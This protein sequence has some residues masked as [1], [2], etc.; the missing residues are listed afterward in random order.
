MSKGRSV[1]CTKIWYS[2][3]HQ[4]LQR[5]KDM[6]EAST[7]AITGWFSFCRRPAAWSTL[8]VT[9]KHSDFIGKRWSRIL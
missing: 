7:G 2:E 6:F 5:T 8:P 3:E 4:Q 9:E 1:E